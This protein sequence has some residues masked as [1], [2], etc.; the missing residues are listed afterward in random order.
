[1]S[2]IEVGINIGKRNLLLIQSENKIDERLY[3][4]ILYLLEGYNFELFEDEIR[5]IPLPKLSGLKIIIYSDLIELEEKTQALLSYT[6]IDKNTNDD[7]IQL[8]ITRLYSLFT[9]RYSLKDIFFT[10]SSYFNNFKPLILE[11]LGT[12]NL[13]IAMPYNN[14]FNPPKPETVE[15]SIALYLNPKLRKK[16]FFSENQILER[17]LRESKVIPSILLKK[18]G[19]YRQI[20]TSKQKQNHL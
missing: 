4:A 13:R 11:I 9:N 12:L 18:T 8:F 1:M 3:T 6:L 10:S 16:E 2:V 7:L 15:W 17:E 20:I 14:I 19:V 5:V